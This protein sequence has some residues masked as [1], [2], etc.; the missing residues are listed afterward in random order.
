MS[1]SVAESLAKGV[2]PFQ[3]QEHKDINQGVVAVE[4][5]RATAEA[6]GRMVIA[7][8]FPRDE[9]Q[10]YANIIE[11]C[12]R[13]SF[14]ESALYS[15]PRGGKKVSGPSIRLAETVAMYWGNIDYGIQELSQKEGYSEMMAYC[16]D[17][18]TNTVSKQQFTVKH[19]RDKRGGGQALTDQ[20]DIYEIAANM[21]A[22]RLR[23]RIL[24]VV[25]SD[26]IEAAVEQVSQT[27]RGGSGEP[28]K[29][30]IK[31]M[32]A[33]FDAVGVGSNTLK[34][35]VGKNLDNLTADDLVDMQGIYRS[36]KDG[37]SKVADWLQEGK[38]DASG[39][40]AE[41]ALKSAGKTDKKPEP[42]KDEE[43]PDADAL[44][45]DESKDDKT[46]KED[47]K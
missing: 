26:V 18:Q 36:I 41:Q 44:F 23:A 4:Q 19:I 40:T 38:Q 34:L 42:K 8:K 1:T 21:G 47:K 46:D 43:V 9:S 5:E 22:R 6:Q 32:I 31:K 2:N 12:K 45:N 24:A 11:A 29:D 10:A 16:W 17:M 25:P 30:R 33:A 14:A 3:K 37:Q 20:R 15:Y 27:L 28:L 13:P 39:T 7:K 35:I